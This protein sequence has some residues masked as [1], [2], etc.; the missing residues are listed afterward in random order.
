MNLQLINFL[1]VP[2]NLGRYKKCL[3][4]RQIKIVQNQEENFI[5]ITPL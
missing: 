4:N 1:Y 5:I 2:V 3:K